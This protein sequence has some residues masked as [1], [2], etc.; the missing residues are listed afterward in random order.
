MLQHG[1]N[2]IITRP[3]GEPS[4]VT[5]NLTDLVRILAHH[6]SRAEQLGKAAQALTET[7]LSP[8]NVQQY[9]VRLLTEYAKLLK[10]KPA[11]HPDA[12]SIERSLTMARP[13]DYHLAN[14]TCALCGRNPSVGNR[15]DWD[16]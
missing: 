10:Y 12:V 2:I 11:V 1:Q 8:S 5:H 6:D 7:V 9:W 14:R 16:W 13:E 15:W 4:H 3:L